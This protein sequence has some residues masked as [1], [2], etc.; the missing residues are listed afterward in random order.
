MPGPIASLVYDVF[1][2]DRRHL[3]KPAAVFFLVLR[4]MAAQPVTYSRDIAPLLLDRCAPCH[5]PGEAAPFSLL[6]LED[7]RR[8]GTQIVRVTGLRY[9]PPWLP[10]PDH[11]DFA[12]AGRLSAEQIEL[13][14]RWVDGGMLPGNP[15]ETPAA[16]RFTPGWQLGEPDLILRMRS[17]YRLAAEGGDVFRNFVLPVELKETR[18]IR[19]MELRPGNKRVVHHANL[20]VDRARRLRRR[21]GEDGQPGFGGM[22]VETESTGDFDPDSHFLFWKPGSA[23]QET[24]EDMA[25][26]L[27]PGSDLIVNLHMQASGKPETIDA[28][29]GLYFA[30]KPPSKFPMLLQLEHDGAIDIPP[31]ARQFRVTDHLRLPVPVQLLAVYPHAHYLGKRV[32]AWAELPGGARVPLLLI[33]NWDINWQAIYTYRKPIDLPAGSTLAMEIVYDNSAGN[34]RNPGHPP[35][36]VTAGNRSADEMGQVWFQA[37][38]VVGEQGSGDEQ[39]PRLELQQALM[40]RRIAKYPHDFEAHFNL[41]AALQSSG[42]PEEA[43]PVLAEAVRLKPGDATAHNNLAVSLL[44]AERYAESAREL[45]EALRLDPAYRNARYNLARVLQQQ[46]DNDGAFR[47]L[48]TYLQAAPD[49]PQAY[50]FAGRLLAAQKRYGESVSFFRKA[51]DLQPGDAAFETNLGAALA[52]SGNLPEAIAAF[53]RALLADPV[54]QTARDNLSRARSGLTKRP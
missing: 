52:Q 18:Y 30:K 14:R 48:R 23:P 32:E 25:W 37:L 38:P 20:V 35:I 24:P 28:T 39:D 40:R 8:H 33:E 29:V 45:R 15:A 54:N 50:E 3:L 1:V 11:G 21:D 13:L 16:P 36:R 10:E 19:A 46:N 42:K 27:D 22:E 2:E 47:E 26:K 34:P 12:G 53:E 31:G 41:G 44:A 7:A 4:A 43:L 51:A 5:R 6:T 17:P 49:D 9:M